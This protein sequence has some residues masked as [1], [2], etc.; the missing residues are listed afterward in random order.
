MRVIGLDTVIEAFALSKKVKLSRQRNSR[1]LLSP[2]L[3]YRLSNGRRCVGAAGGPTLEFQ[4]AF[5][6]APVS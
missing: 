3:I 6:F 2:S 1:G 4:G 5:L